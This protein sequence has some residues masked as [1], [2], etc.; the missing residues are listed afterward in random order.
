[1][2]AIRIPIMA[3]MAAAILVVPVGISAFQQQQAYAP[4][5]VEVVSNSRN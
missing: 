5:T 3:I 2:K 1:M 4:R